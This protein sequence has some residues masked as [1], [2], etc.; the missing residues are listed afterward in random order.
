M[1]TKDV[2]E[3]AVEIARLKKEQDSLEKRTHYS[4]PGKTTNGTKR[5]ARPNYP[6]TC[7]VAEDPQILPRMMLETEKKCLVANK[8]QHMLQSS[9]ALSDGDADTNHGGG[10][11]GSE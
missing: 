8:R 11:V 3:M 4:R 5:V 9:S 7:L 1:M 2:I 10:Q 6:T